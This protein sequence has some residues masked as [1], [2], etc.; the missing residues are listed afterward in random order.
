MLE[1]LKYLLMRVITRKPVAK[2]NSIIDSKA[3]VGN[4]AQI[5]NSTIG[6][7]SYVYESRVINTIIGK[8]CSIAP[9]CSIGGG[10]HPIEWVSTSPVFYRG[11]N[12]FHKNFSDHVFEEFVETHI[13]N[14][15][16]IGSK[17][18]IKGG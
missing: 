14:D 18:L 12:V 5:V 1:E 13:G 8:Y 10:K 2:K 11:N 16:W 3:R 9:E 4:G 6:K 15:V 7:Y 17:C